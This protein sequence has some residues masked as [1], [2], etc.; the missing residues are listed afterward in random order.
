MEVLTIYA[1][2]AIIDVIADYV[3]SVTDSPL[4]LRSLTA[5]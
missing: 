1:I 5:K 4:I 2:Y 3:N